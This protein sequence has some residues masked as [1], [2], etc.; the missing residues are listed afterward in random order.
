[1]DVL[2]ILLNFLGMEKRIPMII[3]TRNP[4]S[5]DSFFNLVR[6]TT[7]IHDTSRI[8]FR[9]KIFHDFDDVVK[10]FGIS[11]GVLIFCMKRK[12][13]TIVKYGTK[14]RFNS[15]YVATPCKPMK[16]EVEDES[17]NKGE[18]DLPRTPQQ[19]IFSDDS[20]IVTER[21]H[22]S[23]NDTNRSNCIEVQLDHAEEV[24]RIILPKNALNF[25][26]FQRIVGEKSG[27]PL[28]TRISFG[29]K[30]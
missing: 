11:E 2:N 16:F 17:D 5:Y 19:E 10:E 4:I 21:L 26:L 12:E 30:V 18:K 1:M 13:P 3:S 24:I 20:N 9:G 29:G 22:P 25:N 15:A 27:I 8:I 14:N 23:I 6:K 7:H 28:S